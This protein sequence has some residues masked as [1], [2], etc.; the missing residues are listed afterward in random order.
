[1]DLY[2][3]EPVFRQTIDRCARCLLDDP[4]SGLDLRRFLLWPTGEADGDASLE[5][6]ALLMSS[7]EVAQ[8]TLFAFEI[9]MATLLRS[10]GIEPAAVLGHSVGEF[11]AATVAGV[12]E[13][14]DALRL[15]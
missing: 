10:W 3:A 7:T 13:L 2:E 8:P 12:F 1:R 5:R 14:E 9:A 4:A 15:V 11:A 6:I